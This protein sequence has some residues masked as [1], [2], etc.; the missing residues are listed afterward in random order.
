VY[1]L[2][3]HASDA[4]GNE[5]TAAAR[6]DGGAVE[7]RLPV[8]ETTTLTAGAIARRGVNAHPLIAYGASVPIHGRVTNAFGHA[9]REVLVQVTERVALPD[10]PWRSIGTVRTD[11]KGGFRF[12]AARGPARTLRFEYSGTPTTRV[13]AAE[14]ALR[15]RAATTLRPS[16]RNL[17][18]GETLVFRGRLLGGPVPARGKVITVQAWTRSGWKT[19]GTSR[20]RARD[21]RW[22]YRYTFTGTTSTSRYRFRAVVPLEASYPYVAGASKVASVLVRGA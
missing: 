5:R 18:N 10:A 22:S 14:V 20:A 9:R 15:V 13:A 21:G 6:P 4:V 12:T 19:F 8:R 1:V 2:R 17:R 11:S 3:A 16:R 7:V